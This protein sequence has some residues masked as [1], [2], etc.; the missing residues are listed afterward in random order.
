MGPFL[1]G[2]FAREAELGH[3]QSIVPGPQASMVVA[4]RLGQLLMQEPFAMMMLQG[5]GVELLV[6]RPGLLAFRHELPVLIRFGLILRVISKRDEMI[7]LANVSGHVLEGDAIRILLAPVVKRRADRFGSLKAGNVM[8]A[9]AA[10]GADRL[11]TDV[12][13]QM[14]LPLLVGLLFELQLVG[15]RALLTNLL[16]LFMLQS[17]GLQNL[18]DI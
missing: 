15:V 10:V 12:P 16:G 17:F 18:G 8:A 6:G 7:M 5:V 9:E 11:L 4:A 14:I 2:R 3:A 13:F 1:R